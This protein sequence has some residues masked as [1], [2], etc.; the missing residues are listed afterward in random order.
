MQFWIAKQCNPPLVAQRLKHRKPST[1]VQLVLQGARSILGGIQNLQLASDVVPPTLLVRQQGK[2][3]PPLLTSTIQHSNLSAS[4]LHLQSPGQHK[5]AE[6]AAA[7]MPAARGS[8]RFSQLASSAFKTSAT[9]PAASAL[10][11]GRLS[12]QA[13][14]LPALQSAVRDSEASHMAAPGFGQMDSA[15][16]SAPN[17]D[18][19][20][21][22]GQ[23][24]QEG[25]R[26]PGTMTQDEWDAFMQTGS[27]PQTSTKNLA[28]GKARG[29]KKA[30]RPVLKKQRMNSIALD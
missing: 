18:A 6:A 12:K 13:M 22:A 21:A 24:N 23:N 10:L 7:S 4:D 3:A 25:A 30:V 2:L 27:A 5:A 1:L 9:S 28:G 11:T 14:P 17:V 8:A 20:T 15:A 19:T 29:R 26:T 16:V